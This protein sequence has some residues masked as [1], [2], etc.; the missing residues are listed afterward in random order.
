MSAA[1][2]AYKYFTTDVFSSRVFG[3]NPLAVVLDADD[4]DSATMQKIAREFN[5]SE[6]T[7]ILKAKHAAGES[8]P[9]PVPGA[10]IY[11]RTRAALR[12]PPDSGARRRSLAHC[13]RAT[14]EANPNP[15]GAQP[16]DIILEEG[17]GNVPGYYRGPLS[18]RRRRLLR[19][20]K[21]RPA[22]SIRAHAAAGSRSARAHSFPGS[23]RHRRRGCARPRIYPA[24]RE[25]G[26]SFA[27]RPRK[28]SNSPGTGPGSPRSL[29]TG[30]ERHVGPGPPTCSPSTRKIRSRKFARGNS[31]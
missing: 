19:S 5:Y 8:G 20:I 29:G 22:D 3:G 26:H 9:P 10:D 24:R 2:K 14:H 27:E 30:L 23:R 16:V 7:F 21:G 25:H 15:K 4:L 17:V 12:R 28:K 11:A 1:A 18:P 31:P 6:T 13:G